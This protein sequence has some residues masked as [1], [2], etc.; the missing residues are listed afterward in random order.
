[1]L[2]NAWA[3]TEASFWDKY[4]IVHVHSRLNLRQKCIVGKPYCLPQM[5][6]LRFFENFYDQSSPKWKSFPKML[7]L[8]FEVFMQ[9]I[10][11]IIFFERIF[12]FC[13]LW[14]DTSIAYVHVYKVCN[15]I[16]YVLCWVSYSKKNWTRAFI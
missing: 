16:V 11:Y 6:K 12:P 3:R 9:P 14:C 2:W 15:S 10:V 1:M 13:P 5:L 4:F 7:I 8:A